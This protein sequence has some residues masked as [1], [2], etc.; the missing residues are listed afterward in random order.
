M[1]GGIDYSIDAL[2]K[3]SKVLEEKMDSIV[4]ALTVDTGGSRISHKETDA[5]MHMIEGYASYAGQVFAPVAR[6]SN[7]DPKIDFEQQYVPY[8]VV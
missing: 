5:I 7:G 8:D 3:W 1:A 2:R 4:A 6:V